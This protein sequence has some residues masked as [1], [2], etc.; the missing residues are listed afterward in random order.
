MAEQIPTGVCSEFE[1]NWV[2]LMKSV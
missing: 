1:G 2:E